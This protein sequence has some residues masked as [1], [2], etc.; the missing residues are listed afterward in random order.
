MGLL[1]ITL[2]LV[3]L[4]SGTSFAGGPVHGAKAAAMGTAFVAIADD[5]SA[6]LHNPAGLTQ[7][8]G[9]NIYSGV[10]LVMPSTTYQSP[11]GQTEDTDFQVFFPPNFFITSD[12]KTERMA[13][14]L[15]IYSPFGIGGRK[16]DES[17]STRF[18][19]TE[20]TIATV[21]VNPTFAWKIT[22]RLSIGLGV[23]YLHSFNDGEVMVDQSSV[24]GQNGKFSIEADGGGWGYNFGF[25][26]SPLEKLSLGFAYRSGVNA[27][28]TGTVKQ[29]NI[30]PAFQPF[31]GGSQFETDVD[32][33]L[34][35]PEIVSLAIAY[36]P[37][38]ALTFGFDVEWIRWSSFNKQDLDL[39][40]EVPAV[41]FT[42]RSI[43]LDW[44]N[45]WLF[46]VGAEYEL[47]D[48]FALRAG[49]AYVE[50]PV[51]EH[52][53]SSASPEANQHNFSIG[54]GYKI[55]KWVVDGFYI[56][57]FVEDREIDNAILSGTYEN[58]THYIG[59]NLGYRF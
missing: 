49:Y 25:L 56:A 30:A 17:G 37:T 11:S 52:T 33:S 58:F 51:P 50:S 8:K 4:L 18:V 35:F 16:W 3:L 15:G 57:G 9:T 59:A 31:F 48:R 2:G 27:D 39:A 28:Q 10:T 6:I 29:E 46:K 34:D 12:L 21:S 7:F 19:S 45:S 44:K 32:T 43:G 23:L 40:T 41:G 36:R 47:N 14:G 26:L 55:G 53:L 1:F 42:D 20:S 22:R 54:F 5:P 38:E 13:V 24:G